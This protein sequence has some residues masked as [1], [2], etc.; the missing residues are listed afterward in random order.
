MKFLSRLFSGWALL[1][2]ALVAAGGYYYYKSQQ[3]PDPS[4]VYRTE[5]VDVGDMVQTVSANGTLNPVTLVSVGT[6]VS[7][8]VRKLYADFNQEVKK[9][10][11]LLELDDA[12]YSAQVR[13]SEANIRNVQATLDLARANEARMQNL[14]N[15]EYVSRL[16][17]DQAIQ[18]RRSA[19]AQIAQAQAQLA[20]DRANLNYTVIRSPVSGVVVARQVDIGQTVAASFQTPELFKIAQD[21]SKMQ[22]HSNFAEADVGQIRVGQPATFSVDAYQDRKF[23][24][25]VQQVRLNPTI[26][27]NVVTYDVVLGVDNPEL[28]LLPGMTSYVSIAVAEQQAALRVPNAALR[29]RPAQNESSR[30]KP[31]AKSSRRQD[32]SV[33]KVYVLRQGKPVAVPVTLGI[34][35]NK[36]TAVLSG[37]LKAGDQVIVGDNS[38]NEDKRS[39]GRGMRMR[40]F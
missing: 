13:Q 40:M 33:R 1:L 29:Y 27:A 37:D 38:S 4:E 28:I 24:A 11:I 34:T 9:G 14:F 7:G 17:L 16:E 32:G 36:Y 20:R 35:D 22:I 10:Q 26:Q 18:A 6:Q 5:E 2:L 8:T 31:K 12:I 3:Q 21:L 15:L 23:S 30:D 39:D 19:E 25:V